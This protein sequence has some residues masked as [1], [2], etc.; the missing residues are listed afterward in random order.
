MGLCPSQRQQR[1]RALIVGA[2]DAGEMMVR[3]DPPGDDGYAPVA[4]V[5][6]DPI[7]YGSMI[8]G[9]P[10]LGGRTGPARPAAGRQG[11]L[12][13]AFGAR[14]TVRDRSV[15]KTPRQAQIAGSA[16]SR[17]QVHVSDLRQ[18]QVEDR[19]V[20]SLPSSIST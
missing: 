1:Q 6:D 13:C 12:I 8:H 4:F 20:V 10:V 19:S 5:D 2:G 14:K 18:V 11:H 16:A 17:R 15:C 3:D 7:K 9:V